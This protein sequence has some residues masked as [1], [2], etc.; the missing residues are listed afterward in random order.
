MPDQVGK[1]RRWTVVRTASTRASSAHWT[2]LSR[3]LGA[4][5]RL[6]QGSFELHFDKVRTC[7][8]LKVVTIRLIRHILEKKDYGIPRV[9]IELTTLVSQWDRLVV[10]VRF[11]KGSLVNLRV[12][13]DL[14]S[15]CRAP[16]AADR[17]PR[18]DPKPVRWRNGQKKALHM[19]WLE[20]RSSSILC[21]YFQTL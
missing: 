12:P 18:L 9:V 7:V 1:P 17:Y 20:Y 11:T 16:R 10:V 5:L 4:G 15:S 14:W 3:H 13:L 8:L 19:L 6:K 21:L 2:R